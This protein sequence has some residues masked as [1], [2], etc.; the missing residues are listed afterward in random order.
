MNRKTKALWVRVLNEAPLHVRRRASSYLRR[1]K[2]LSERSWLVWS[3]EGTQY[4]VCL[5][6]ADV[7]CSCPYG[8][9]EKG[10]CKHICAVAVHELVQVEVKPWLKK[11]EEKL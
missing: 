3:R 7:S 8:E 4:R 11:L 1:V 5:E 6:K 2:K 10:Y 9:R